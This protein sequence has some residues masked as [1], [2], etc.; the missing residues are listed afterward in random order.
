MKII[1]AMHNTYPA[2]RISKTKP[3]IEFLALEYETLFGR[4]A[5]SLDSIPL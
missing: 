4:A 2:V 3:G 5:Q 1:H